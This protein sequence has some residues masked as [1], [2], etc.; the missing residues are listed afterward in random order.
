MVAEIQNFYKETLKEN[1]GVGTG[2]FYVS[3]KPSIT[4]GYLVISPNSSILREIVKYTAVGTDSKGDYVTISQRGL[5]GTT[6]Q[7]HFTGE[8]IRMNLTAEHWKEL[9]DGKIDV[10]AGYDSVQDIID[11]INSVGIAGAPN[12]SETVKGIGEV[13]T[14][15]QID[16]GTTTGETGA[17][18]LVSPNN[19]AESKYNLQLPTANEKLA[20]QGTGGTPSNTNRFLTD[21]DTLGT[22]KVVRESN[23]ISSFKGTGVDG[24]LT[25]SSGV[26]N[27]NLGG[28]A[29][30]TKQYTQ[31]AITGT[32]QVTFSNPH[33]N[34]TIIRLKSQG[35]VSLTSST[36][37]NLDASGMGA[38]GGTGSIQATTTPNAGG[39]GLVGN[40]IL[41]ALTTHGGA[42]VT[43]GVIVTANNLYSFSEVALARG[44]VTLM[45]GSGG[46]GGSGGADGN[47]QGVSGGD[48]GRGGG[49]LQINCG[50]ALNF[51]STLGIS[52]AGKNGANGVNKSSTNGAAATGAGGGGS[53]GTCF[54]FYN[55]LTA[56]TGTINSAGGAGGTGGQSTDTGGGS[57]GIVILGGAGGGG[58]GS[59][60]GAGG[61]GGAES[62]NTNG[63]VG[64]NAGGARAGGGG[65]SG[66]SSAF[67]ST[68]VRTG[69]VGGSA[70]ASENALV[71]K[72]EFFS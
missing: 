29:V 32:G 35:N 43:G 69:G 14:E 48:G 15:T 56:G 38:L 46:G 21:D 70:G 40:G 26:T 64:S 68:A 5:G 41:D 57:G 67:N 23:A 54:V 52:V 58:G 18:L 65:G 50:G 7:E 22:G 59:Y 42:G 71:T 8:P 45:C 53:G 12:A 47:S 4:S 11:Y 72:N 36:I 24:D 33:A 27:I 6:A 51:T 30:V 60:A 31:I 49:A 10:V 28:L 61:N 13:A 37:P 66:G 17:I 62:N 2:N 19:L 25:I 34:G 44:L 63:A 1:W 39:T 20:M 3:S 55:T 9:I 16:A